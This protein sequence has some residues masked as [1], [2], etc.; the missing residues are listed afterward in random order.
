MKRVIGSVPY[1]NAKPLIRWFDTEAGKRSGYQVIEATPSVLAQMLEKGEISLALVSSFF[2][3]THPQYKFIEDVSISGQSE[4]RSVKAFSRLPFGM[5]Q[6]VAMDTSS[7]TSVALLLILLDE[8][9]DSHPQRL[10]HPPDLKAMLAVAD[11]ALLI[12]DPGMLA[13]ERGLKVLDLGEAWRRHTGKPFVYALWVGM[14][15][16]VDEEARQIL[17]EAKEYGLTQLEAIAD[18]EAVRLQYP[19]SLC[20][21]YLTSVMDYNL[22]A[23]LRE[24]LEL[25]RRK[26]AEHGLLSG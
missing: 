15:E 9:Y 7:L 6:S 2:W 14:P 13:K 19:V 21:D 5:V 23:P 11:A 25:F 26:C 3:F 8:V 22:D 20:R 17:Q 12:G 10:Y 16:D 24:G 1:L 18:E 4:I